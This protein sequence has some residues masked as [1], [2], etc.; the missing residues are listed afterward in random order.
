MLN[1]IDRSFSF[2]L[3]H[4]SSHRAA[5]SAALTLAFFVLTVPAIAQSPP[6]L[7]LGTGEHDL[8]H[9]ESLVYVEV[10]VAAAGWLALETRAATIGD[11]DPTLDYTGEVSGSAAVDFEERLS[12]AIVEVSSTGRHRFA[13]ATVAPSYGLGSYRLRIDF[14]TENLSAQSG[15]SGNNGGDDI[16][17]APQAGSDDLLFALAAAGAC[18]GVDRIFA[19]PDQLYVSQAGSLSGSADAEVFS[20]ELDGPTTVDL[21][22]TTTGTE[23]AI[24]DLDGHRLSP[25]ARSATQ[26]PLEEGT[27]FTR[28]RGTAG[29][30]TLTASEN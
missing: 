7:L 17:G 18:D 8:T 23:A 20:F 30:Y 11:D 25:S 16:L 5:L 24:F 28:I 2:F 9:T 1:R 15:G 14:L 27:Y 12:S 21:T 3:S 13:L 22:L 4:R 10:D 6:T 19:C 26:W 29:T